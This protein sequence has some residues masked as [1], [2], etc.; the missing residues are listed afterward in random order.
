MLANSKK[1][2]LD[3]VTPSDCD[4]IVLDDRALL[5]MLALLKG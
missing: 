5:E 1:A 2:I 4:F 3:N